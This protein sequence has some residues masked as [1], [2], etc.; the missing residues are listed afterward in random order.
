M[1]EQDALIRLQHSTLG[2][3]PRA[4]AMLVGDAGMPMPIWCRGG[5]R[6]WRA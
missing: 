2:V 6:G 4:C 5:Q 3:H 1:N